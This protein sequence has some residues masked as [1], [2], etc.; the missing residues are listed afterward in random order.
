MKTDGMANSR[1]KVQ[2]RDELHSLEILDRIAS[3]KN[4]YSFVCANGKDVIRAAEQGAEAIRF[5][6]RLDEKLKMWEVIDERNV[7]VLSQDS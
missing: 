3:G 7:S 6:Q 2:M 4:I 1:R 5:K